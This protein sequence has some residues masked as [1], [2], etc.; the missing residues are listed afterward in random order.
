MLYS[1]PTCHADELGASSFVC[2][3]C[4]EGLTGDVCEECVPGYYGDTIQGCL[5]CECNPQG[6]RDSICNATT[7]QCNCYQGIL[8]RACDQCAERHAVKDG[9]CIP[10]NVDCTGE[11]FEVIDQV[12]NQIQSMNITV[13]YLLPWQHLT[14]VDDDVA[15]LTQLGSIQVKPDTS[16]LDAVAQ[17]ISEL[18]SFGQKLE[19]TWDLVARRA[20][21]AHGEDKQTKTAASELAKEIVDELGDVQSYTE[22]ALSDIL[23]R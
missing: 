17:N 12:E 23:G 2:D 10:C 15:H 11:L 14:D 20:Q 18:E 7:G 19:D 6:S 13:E 22:N 16:F 3:E 21:K 9:L 4:P 5:K 1:R 8:G